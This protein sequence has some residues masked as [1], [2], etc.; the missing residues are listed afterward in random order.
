M[1]HQQALAISRFK[2][3]KHLLTLSEDDFRDKVIRPLFLRQGLTDGRDLCGPTEH[4]K[5]AIFIYLDPIGIRNIYV[6]QTKKGNINLSSDASQ[7]LLRAIT[8]L[9]TAL[10]TPV[11]FSG[12]RA[13]CY[14]AK[15]ILCASGKINEA[16]RIHIVEDVSDLRLEFFDSDDLIPLIDSYYP[17]FWYGI[18]TDMV[19][20]FGALKSALEDPRDN[21]IITE[22]SHE[23]RLA[24]SATDSFF[25]PLLLHRSYLKKIKAKGRFEEKLQFE[26]FPATGIINKKDNHSFIIGE[27]GSGKSTVLKRIAYTLSTQSLS[28]DSIIRIPVFIRAIDIA[29]TLDLTLLEIMRQNT[30]SILKNDRECFSLDDLVK[31][32]LVVLVDALDEIADDQGRR[33]VLEIISRF[34]SVYPLCKVV[35]SSRDIPSVL[36]MPE[37]QYYVQ[38]RLS[39]LNIRQAEQIVKRLQTVRHL[40]EEQAEEILR[41]IQDVHGMVLNPLLVTVFASTAEYSRKDIPANITELFKKYT[42]LMLGRWDTSKGLAHQFHAPLKDFLLTQVAYEMHRRQVTYL[43]LEEFKNIIEVELLKRGHKPD[44]LAQLLDEIIYRSGLFQILGDKIEFK[45]LLLQEFFAGRGIPSSGLLE[46]LITT[47]WWQRAIVFYFGGKPDDIDS[48]STAISR[49][50]TKPLSEIY[51]AALAA[52]LSIQTCYLAEVA[53][54]IPLMTWVIEKLSESKAPYIAASEQQDKF[55]LMIFLSYYIYGRD[56][57]AFAALEDI[58]EQLAAKW[59]ADGLTDDQKETRVFWSIVGL[60]ESGFLDKA[61][62][63]IKKFRPGDQRLLL[64]IYLGCSLIQHLRVTT[65]ENKKIAER[66][67]NRLSGPV[68][69]YRSQLLKEFKSELLEIR[70]G[71]IKAIE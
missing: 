5:D 18:E 28:S 7:N 65:K 38:Y 6:V 37:I 25:V 41:R 31:G 47:E 27:A 54:K 19:P 23:D 68:M 56:S 51:F 36:N 40:P 3:G 52:G 57:V 17:E 66:I 67:C 1:D 70:K 64:A 39:P 34:T 55:P 59:D 12:S 29:K 15:V 53:K 43:D 44:L 35:I 26:E 2:K 46:S 22:L 21:L 30:R 4:G 61:E 16:A 32:H 24:G 71:K 20:Y 49:L 63:L 11:Y 33:R 45:H 14:P 58:V 50:D 13:K 62:A 60:L 9:H 48:I 8:Q 69:D 42:E 10:K